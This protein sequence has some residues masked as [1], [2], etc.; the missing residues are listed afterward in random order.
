[1]DICDTWK[2]Q[3]L[4]PLSMPFSPG[5]TLRYSIATDVYC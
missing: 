2:L 1:M 4:L 3:P 5:L